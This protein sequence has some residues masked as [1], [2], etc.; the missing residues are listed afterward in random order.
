MQ[1]RRKIKTFE[2]A[3]GVGGGITSVY[4]SFP[5]CVQSRYTRGFSNGTVLCGDVFVIMCCSGKIKISLI[6]SRIPP[7]PYRGSRESGT[8]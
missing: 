7:G 6:A 3:E 5:S 1:A 8:A 4:Y 2:G